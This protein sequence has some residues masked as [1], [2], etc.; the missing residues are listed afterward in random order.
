MEYLYR[1]CN[2]ARV[3]NIFSHRLY[4][5]DD[6]NNTS[7]FAVLIKC[8]CVSAC[9]CECASDSGRVCICARVRAS[10]NLHNS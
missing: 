7:N 10:L 4:F 3:S 1:F 5:I 2:D 8:V 6:E 9:V